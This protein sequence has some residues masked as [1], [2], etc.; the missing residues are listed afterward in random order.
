[1]KRRAVLIASAL[2][3]IAVFGSSAAGAWDV[4][5]RVPRRPS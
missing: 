1:M 5:V 3:C 2:A 4:G